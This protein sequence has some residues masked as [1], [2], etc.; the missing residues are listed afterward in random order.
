MGFAH[1]HSE[2]VPASTAR[3]YQ[4]AA[5]QRF[6]IVAHEGAQVCDAAFVGADDHSVTYS[7]DL[8]VLFNQLEGTGDIHSLETLYS[9]PPDTEPMVRVTED[10][11]GHHFPWAGGMC[12]SYLYEIRDDEPS[13]E[14]CADNLLT[15]LNERGLSLEKVPEVFNIGM[16]VTVE[17]DQIQYLPP[18]FGRGDYIELEPQIDLIVGI[19]SCPND[20]TIMNESEPK[21]LEIQFEDPPR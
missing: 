6:R 13:H 9:R 15:A 1:S 19:S 21:S 14:N 5:H 17:D 10:T 11:I 7:S 20:T 16:H 18:E 12:C 8:S 3:A 2:V 4:V